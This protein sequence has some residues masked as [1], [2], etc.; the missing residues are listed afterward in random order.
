[1]NR[2]RVLLFGDALALLLFLVIGEIQHDLLG[3]PDLVLKVI[4]QFGAFGAA[5][6]AMAWALGALT[7]QTPFVTWPFLGRSLLAW[8]FAAPAG[9]VLRAIL[10]N[11][12]AIVMPFVI[13]AT[14]FGG[15]ILL[16]WRVVYALAQTLLDRRLRP[17]AADSR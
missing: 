2:H 4:L 17:S 14:G 16:G 11:Q 5:W 10:L 1:M 13:A 8:L 12:A 6:W 15:L 3:A 9:V 7:I